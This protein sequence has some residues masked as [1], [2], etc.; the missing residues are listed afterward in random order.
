MRE[1]ESNNMKELI[2]L[3]CVLAFL[4]SESPSYGEEVGEKKNPTAATLKVSMRLILV[5]GEGARIVYR[6][7]NLSKER[8]D[9]RTDRFW[10]RKCKC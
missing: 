3:I 1:R 6:L 5:E 2:L 9:L 7:R 8:L 4:P 10:G